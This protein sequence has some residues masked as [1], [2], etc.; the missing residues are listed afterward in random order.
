M[1]FP[2]DQRELTIAVYLLFS[3]FVFLCNCSVSFIE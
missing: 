3:Y 1:N 2:V